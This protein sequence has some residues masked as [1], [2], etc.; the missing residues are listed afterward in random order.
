MDLNVTD[1]VAIVT[2]GSRGIG[3]AIC[4]KLGSEGV[5]VGVNYLVNDTVNL[6]DEAQEVV[7]EIESGGGTAAAIGGDISIETDAIGLF[8]QCEEAFGQPVEILVNNAAVVSTGRIADFSVDHWES[9]FR[10]NVTGVFITCR[11]FIKRLDA[12]GKPGKIVNIA[13]QAAF[14]AS[15]TGHLPYDSSKG[16]VISMTRAIA[17]ETAERGFDA[18]CIAPGM[19]MTEMVAKTWEEKKHRYLSNIP[20][21]RIARPEEVANVVLFLA[22]DLSSYMTGTCLD[23]T[24]GML[25]R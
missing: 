22:S 19:V 9:Q 23:V 4:L 5:K 8:D 7:A 10:I 14:L 11:E 15:T 12:A 20:K 6:E 24:G 3:K 1:K 21:N 2:G 16:A 13:S 18:N 25:M 17:R